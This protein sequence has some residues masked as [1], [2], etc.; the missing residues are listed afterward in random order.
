M[1]SCLYFLKKFLRSPK[2]Y[3]IRFFYRGFRIQFQFL[4]KDD[5]GRR[6]SSWGAGNA[7]RVHVAEID[8]FHEIKKVTVVNPLERIQD[9]S[10]DLYESLVLNLFART[11]NDGS[12]II[13]IGTFEGNTTI[14]LAKNAKGSRV[15]SIDLPDSKV[16]YALL[17]NQNENNDRKL[18]TFSTQGIQKDVSDNIFLIKQDSGTINFKKMFEVAD[19]CFIDGNHS[20]AYIKS[21][22]LG[23]Y[24]IL[25]QGGLIIWH[26]YGYIYA[27][28]KFI[29]MW[30]KQNQ[31][32]VQVVEGTRLAYA[33]KN[34]N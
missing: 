1:K 21:D 7:R 11:L 3:S 12:K 4:L 28:T 30:A 32:L 22:T 23:C 31:I 10:L 15:F 27:V 8:A 20:S 18:I 13:E 9:M 6:I 25:K 2:Y 5:Y 34:S 33:Y 17:V 26:D 24:S 16:Q 19:L 29:D 14:N